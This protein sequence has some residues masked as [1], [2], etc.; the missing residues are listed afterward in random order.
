VRN[1]KTKERGVHESWAVAKGCFRNGLILISAGSNTL[2]V[3]PPPN[4]T[5]EELGEGIGVM[6]SAI[7]KVDSEA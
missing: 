6:E 2:R 3:V 7:A 5:V 1:K 4:E